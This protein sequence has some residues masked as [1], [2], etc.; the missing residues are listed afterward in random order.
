MKFHPHILNWLPDNKPTQV[1]VRSFKD[2][3][4]SLL[5]DQQLMIEENLSFPNYSTPLSPDNNPELN[6]NS[7]ISELHHGSWWKSSWK[8]IC[9]PNLQEILVPIIFYMDG[10]SLDAHGRLRLTPLNMTLGI[11]NVETRSRPEAWTTI[12]FHPDPEWESTRHSRPAT[13]KE[14]IQN[15]HNGLEVAFRSFKAACNE[16][17]GIEWNYLPYANQ[18]WRVKMKF[19]IAYV[20]GDTELHDKLCGKYGSFNKGVMRM[21]RHCNCYSPNI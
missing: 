12:Y 21:C 1:Y 14:K 7:V 3:I 2:A 6:P 8:E 10:I 11:F 16:D 17:G 13:S 18:Q 19:A 4:Y 15:L 5:S 20:I 9:N